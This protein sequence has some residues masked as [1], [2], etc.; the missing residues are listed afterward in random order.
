M[1]NS[2]QNRKRRSSL[3]AKKGVRSNLSVR[4]G[5]EVRAWSESG[6]SVVLRPESRTEWELIAKSRD[7]GRSSPATAGRVPARTYAYLCVCTPWKKRRRQGV[8]AEATP[9]AGHAPR[10]A[11]ERETARKHYSCPA[12]FPL[13]GSPHLPDI[14]INYG[15]WRPTASATRATPRLRRGYGVVVRGND[16]S[17]RMSYP[18]APSCAGSDLRDPTTYVSVL[19]ETIQK[20]R[21]N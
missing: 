8:S 12:F 18:G 6:S 11:A 14:I 1:R 17:V 3:K 9:S 10:K 15:S 19:S 20:R 2:N 4:P 13:I 5:S 16:L 7:N 21:R